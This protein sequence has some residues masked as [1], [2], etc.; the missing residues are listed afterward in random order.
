MAVNNDDRLKLVAAVNRTICT[1]ATNDWRKV[2]MAGCQ[3][4]EIDTAQ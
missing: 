1:H 2:E 4:L 3:I